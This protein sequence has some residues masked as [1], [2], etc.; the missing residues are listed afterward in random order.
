MSENWSHH[1]DY[2]YILEML[3]AYAVW[4]CIFNLSDENRGGFFRQCSRC[5]KYQLHYNIDLILLV[6]FFLFAK[7][8]V[9]CFSFAA[10]YA[11]GQQVQP[12]VGSENSGLRQ[13]HRESLQGVQRGW[14]DLYINLPSQKKKQDKNVHQP[15]NSPFLTYQSLHHLLYHNIVVSQKLRPHEKL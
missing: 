1:F 8:V 5:L 2:I 9:T 15:L 14:S 7:P 10:N 12:G 3:K 6:L 4:I 13:R 11:H